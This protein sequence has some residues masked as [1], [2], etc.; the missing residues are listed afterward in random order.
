MTEI[1][2]I[3]VRYKEA[4]F[5]E[6]ELA[7]A[8]ESVA[9]LDEPIFEEDNSHCSNRWLTSWL[10]CFSRAIWCSTCCATNAIACRRIYWQ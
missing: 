9:F 6:N 8:I 3:Q 4:E 1:T 10:T 7:E 5:T 2:P